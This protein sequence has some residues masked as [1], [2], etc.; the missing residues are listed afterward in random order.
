M[1]KSPKT[2]N[3]AASDNPL[4][5]PPALPYGA[6]AF[7][8]IKTEHFM[9]A[10]EW[11]LEKV[12]EEIKAIKENKDDPS[13]ENTI[14]ALENAGSDFER[15]AS[16]FGTFTSNNTTPELQ[17]LEK[18]VNDLT[19]PVFSKIAMD[20]TLF[21]RIKTV[22]DEKDTLGLDAEESMLLERTFKKRERSG[23]LLKDEDK[24][25]LQEIDQQL[26]D[27]STQFEQN[28]TNSTAAYY[29]ITTLDELEG[30]P[31]RSIKSYQEAA[32]SMLK[33]AQ[34]LLRET[35]IKLKTLQ[36]VKQSDFKNPMIAKR[37]VKEAE[38]DVEAARKVLEPLE[39]MPKD[40]CVL[41]LQPFPSE[42][43]SHCKNRELRKEMLEA[44]ANVASEA[45]FDN[46][47]L[48]TEIVA[49][50][51]E[52]AQ[53]LG[54]ENHADFILSNRMAGSQKAVD[55]FLENNRQAY[56]PSAQDFFEKTKDFALASGDIDTFE[57]HD[58]AYYDRMRAEQLFNFDDELLRPYL[59][60][61][62]V[63]KGFQAHVEELFNVEM[64]D[65]TD[66]YPAYRDDAQV[67]EV[68]D[69][70]NGEV[71][72]LFYADY[73]AD[74]KAKRGGAWMNELRGA[75]IDKDGQ[76]TI[77]I[78][79]NSCNYQKP[80]PGQ[81]SLLS[82]GEVETL[83]HE[84]GHGFHGALTKG[85]YAS[86]NG[87]N[88]KWDFV[89]LPSQLMENWVREPSVLQKF[90]VHYETGEPIPAE[91]IEK[92][93]EKGNYDAGYMGL[94][95]TSL[96][97]IDMG[98][99]GD[100]EPGTIDEVEDKV[101]A[102]TSFFP[103]RKASMSQRFGHLF[104]G[105]YSAGY[106]SYKWAE[107]LEADIFEEFKKNGLYDPE[108]AKRLKET[109]YTKGGQVDPMDLFKEMMGR[110]PNPDAL[111]RREG[112]L[113]DTKSAAPETS[114]QQTAPDNLPDIGQP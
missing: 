111:L 36:D 102:L 39:N 23:A 71:V 95:Q 61:G 94:R 100:T 81:P 3:A 68:T 1:A 47:P 92:I 57:P 53:L 64:V 83:F 66:K 77:P 78:I 90:A 19:T 43:M 108:T 84:G 33:D 104:A 46:R 27:K 20:E 4:I 73:F 109:I 70:D 93:T 9:P 21:N 76:K 8:K 55:E 14:E 103:E 30:V 40:A 32:Q 114:T 50:R 69:K 80:T 87:P 34:D 24:N 99:H 60:V 75:S 101:H 45:P 113:P 112:I 58:M 88:V 41:Q 44:A 49:L 38:K 67:F 17:K 28:T 106:Y 26:S 42:V 72:A 59:E 82:L 10:I 65:C 48:V 31:E 107:V 5:N 56:M 22:Y 15:I 85:K 7:D 25:R 6:P 16:I 54:Y 52:R 91:Y 79:T 12:Q 2:F 105:G 37:Y 51:H 74:A 18:K 13:F 62:N 89:E 97:M 29:R 63:L 35:E 86:Q 98:W 11:A 96:G 110:E